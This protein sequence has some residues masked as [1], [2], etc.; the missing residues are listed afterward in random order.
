MLIMAEIACQNQ[1]EH[2]VRRLEIHDADDHTLTAHR[3]AEHGHS[4]LESE[5]SSLPF[6]ERHLNPIS[7]CYNSLTTELGGG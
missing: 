3:D 5:H 2:C 6:A 1:N 7:F 4:S